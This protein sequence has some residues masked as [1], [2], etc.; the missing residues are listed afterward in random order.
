MKTQ[1]SR[2][3]HALAVAMSMAVCG[4]AQAHDPTA[5][6]E[7]TLRGLYI[8]NATGFD[9]VNNAAVPKALVESILFNGD[10]TLS[11]P[12]A[13]VSINGNI[14]SFA[15]V[16][17]TYAVESDCTGT[18]SFGSIATWDLFISPGG[19][20]IFMIQTAPGSP[21]FEGIA[22]RVKR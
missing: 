10:G 17:G 14:L 7:T 13:T 21:V 22:K 12:D 2:S 5:C 20:E 3:V 6:R 9:I 19:A 18:L 1:T 15:D 8:L 11:S 4:V 16:P